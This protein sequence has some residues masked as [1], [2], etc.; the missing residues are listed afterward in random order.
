MTGIWGDDKGT[1]WSERGQR[2]QKGDKGHGQ[3]MAGTPRG[4]VTR[5]Q[6]RDSGPGEGD[7][8]PK[9]WVTRAHR[10]QVDK[11]LKW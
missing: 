6:G 11:H 5:T 8:D 3:G 7:R 1:R 4:W 10:G 2:T 9:G